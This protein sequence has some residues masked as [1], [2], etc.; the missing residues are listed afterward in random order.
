MKTGTRDGLVATLVRMMV[1]LAVVACASGVRGARAQVPTLLGDLS[2][3]QGLATV[4]ADPA[5]YALVDGR[6]FFTAGGRGPGTTTDGQYAYSMLPDGSDVRNHGRL[7]LGVIGGDSVVAN[8]GRVGNRY[9]VGV[10][11]SITNIRELR[12]FRAESTEGN[13]FITYPS[14]AFVQGVTVVRAAARSFVLSVGGSSGFVHVADDSDGVARLVHTV[15]GSINS[16]AF[17]GRTTGAL[18]G[19]SLV[20]IGSDAT[21]KQ[22]IWITDGTAAGTRQIAAINPSG[23]VWVFN[24]MTSLPG[25]VV[26]IGPNPSGGSAVWK[27]DG[28]EAGT[29]LV[30]SL[31][32]LGVASGSPSVS[33]SAALGARAVMTV[34]GGLV[35][36]DGTPDGTFGISGVSGGA[37]FAGTRSAGLV[38]GGTRVVFQAISNTNQ[39]LLCAADGSPTGTQLLATT[40]VS[41]YPFSNAPIA[42]STVLLQRGPIGVTPGTISALIATDGTPEGTVVRPLAT[43]RPFPSIAANLPI[44]GGVLFTASGPQTDPL[45]G[46]INNQPWQSDGTPESTRQL[47]QVIPNPPAGGVAILGRL[48]ERVA[49]TSN[50]FLFLTDGSTGQAIGETRVQNTIRPWAELG[51]SAIFA[52]GAAPSGPWIT[53]GSAA[54]TSRLFTSGALASSE[55]SLLTPLNGFVYFVGTD[56]EQFIPVL[57]R[58]DGTVQGTTVVF[59]APDQ[60]VLDVTA[61]AGQVWFVTT[62]RLE[63]GSR[64]SLYRSDG[65]AEGT[66]LVRSIGQGSVYFVGSTADRLY[67][68]WQVSGSS[69]RA[70]AADGTSSAVGLSAFA[71]STVTDGTALYFMTNLVD[72]SGDFTISQQLIRCAP[73]GPAT[74]VYAATTN[75]TVNGGTL[76]RRMAILGNKIIFVKNDQTSGVEPWAFDQ[77]TQQATLL[78]DIFPGPASSNVERMQT[79]GDRVYFVAVSPDAGRQLWSTD[80]T[81]EGTRQIPSIN[82]LGLSS[83]EPEQVF[84]AATGNDRFALL[85]SRVLFAADDGVVGEEPWLVGVCAADFNSDTTV[86]ADDLGDFITAYF[87]GCP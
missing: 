63:Y 69:I 45:D 58:S 9:V 1:I 87:N 15:E 85:G 21:R 20:F 31:S 71:Y 41:L 26:F 48:G 84:P 14:D 28:T 61:F 64:Y 19:D 29:V 38:I 72:Q 50:E 44:E 76:L 2:P 37:T 5:N 32:E 18:L 35:S 23:F 4:N 8:V 80:G 65:T 12:S 46:I 59:N 82:T 77:S 22:Q 3:G 40:P 49:I 74:V 39:W 60:V 24:L 51:S 6:I 34:G 75:A 54:G 62:P 56:S 68:H 42:Q 36:T 73:P 78:R 27:T 53:D 55:V 79:V 67:V 47:T 30:K 13:A 66:T 52:G 17:V 83:V 57:Y 33:F 10:G 11:P 43:G 86:N 25:Q 7:S 16:E 70:F 81:P